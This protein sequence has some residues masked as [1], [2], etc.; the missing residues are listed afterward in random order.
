MVEP[1]TSGS[2]EFPESPFPAETSGASRWHFSGQSPVEPQRPKRQ[3]GSID[4][5]RM[6]AITS[7]TERRINCLFE[8]RAFSIIAIMYLNN[9]GRKEESQGK[10]HIL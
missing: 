4:K 2:G 8:R 1:K 5:I 3:P 7:A 10:I 9:T 6:A